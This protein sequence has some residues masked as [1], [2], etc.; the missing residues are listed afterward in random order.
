MRSPA[1]RLRP[2]VSRDR[3]G[4]AERR[5]NMRF[6]RDARLVLQFVSHQQSEERL[7][8]NMLL[9][10]AAATA[11][12]SA[13]LM[14]VGAQANAL[15]GSA[16]VRSAIDAV[17]NIDNVG[18]WRSGWHGRGWYPDCG[19]WGGGWHRRRWGDDRLGRRRPPPGRPRHRG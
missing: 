7:M 19:G 15:G 17:G 2:W 1:R 4:A 12:V 13:A 5:M 9:S 6:S 11:L 8:R 16:G 3:R 14:P 10:A 18:C